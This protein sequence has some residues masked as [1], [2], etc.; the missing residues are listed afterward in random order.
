[1][2]PAAHAAGAA[3]AAFYVITRTTSE[4]ALWDTITALGLM[5]CFYYGITALAPGWGGVI[6]LIVYRLRPW[7]FRGQVLARGI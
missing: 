3:A 1:V 4:N 2:V 6:L 5:I 7:F